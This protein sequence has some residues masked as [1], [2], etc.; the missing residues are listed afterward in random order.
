MVHVV[1]IECRL[2]NHHIINKDTYYG[3][4]PGSVKQL[5]YLGVGLPSLPYT[6]VLV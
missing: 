1:S 3:M 6:L 2:I 4:S 5:S